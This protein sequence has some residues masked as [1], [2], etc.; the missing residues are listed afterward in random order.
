MGTYLYMR[1]VGEYINLN[2]VNKFPLIDSSQTKYLGFFT[3]NKAMT[4]MNL[5]LCSSTP[6]HFNL[7]KIY[8]KADSVMEEKIV[9]G[10]ETSKKLV[11]VKN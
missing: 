3:F 7:C 8:D 1:K 6:F 4:F 5:Q 10:T 11:R 9:L 2:Y